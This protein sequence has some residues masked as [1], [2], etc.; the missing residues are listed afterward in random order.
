MPDHHSPGP[1]PSRSASSISLTTL[2]RT[3]STIILTTLP[4]PAL[5]TEHQ[6]THRQII[7]E[8]TI[9]VLPALLISV[10]GSILAGYILG[11][12]QGEAAFDR[13]PALFIM[14]PILLNL[15]SNIELNMSTRLST[16]ANLG[17]FDRRRKGLAV[18]RSNMELLLLQSAAIGAAV[19]LIS[20]LLALIPSR[21][22]ASTPSAR[23]FFQQSA[24]LLATG[25][26]C[27]LLGSAIIGVLICATV[28][29]SHALGIDPDN[30][31]TPIASSFGDMSTL[32]ILSL[33]TS[34]LIAHIN[35]PWPLALVLIVLTLTVLLFR[36]VAR[37]EHM[38]H[39][40]GQGWLPLVYAAATSSIA[41]IVV[42]KYAE[43]FPGMPALVPVMNGIGGNIGTVF[44]SRLSTSLHRAS[45]RDA[46]VGAAEH[47]LVM[48]ILLFINIPVQL[49]FLAMHRLVDASLHV[50][51]GF[52]LVYVAATILHGLAMLLLGRLACTF[53]WAKGYD[54]DDYVNP[55]IT[56]T[57]D[58]LGTLLLALVFLLV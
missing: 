19:G 24:L 57:G 17:T 48:C 37:N 23:D 34:L 16:Q 3:S 44:A 35:T 51:L 10:A 5:P 4:H 12:I 32:L 6:K 29:A 30:I 42:E 9:E 27:A 50:T 55:F 26:G 20:S 22:N 47:N 49:G 28:W 58:M 25:L 7:S 8:L 53:L 36:I 45:R 11:R 39:H 2:P 33:A 13:V 21:G 46:G 52:V 14:V 56:G 54:P 38:A 18:M 15:K 43:R 41:G 1:P 40:I 31:G